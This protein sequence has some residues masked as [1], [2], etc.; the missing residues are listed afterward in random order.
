MGCFH[1]CPMPPILIVP[2]YLNSGPGHWQSLWEAQMRNAHRV[3]MPN[4][5]FPRRIEW[6]EA[7]D[8]AIRK[9]NDEGAPPLL[10]GHSLGCLAIVHWAEAYD[11]PV[12]GALLVAPTDV[13]STSTLDVLRGFAPV[14]R[15]GLPFPCRVVASSDDPYLPILRARAFASAWDAVLSEIG[16][17]GHINA[18][19][20]F[21]DWP[22]GEALLRE[23]M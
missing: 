4:W 10:V 13:E 3:E 7:L 8:E 23:L 12:H 20:G 2:G 5:E 14:P 16:P 22:R 11:R 18:A 21:G 1:G 15:F 19:S 9:A 17:A 6:M